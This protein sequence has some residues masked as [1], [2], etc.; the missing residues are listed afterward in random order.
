MQ[1]ACERKTQAIWLHVRDDNP[2]AIDL[3][4]QLGFTERARRT[5]WQAHTDSNAQMNFPNV[6]IAGRNPR[7]W[8]LQLNWLK[9][10]YPDPLAWHRQWNFNHLRPGFF[11]WLYLL[12]VDIEVRQ[13][14]AMK[15]DSPEAFLAWIPSG[16]GESLFAAA[17]ERSDPEALTALLLKA[18]RDL[19]RFYPRVQM[20]FPA[21]QFEQAIQNAGFQ[22][23]RTLIWMQATS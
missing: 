12:F 6:T 1:Y 10:L 21:G 2:G 14:A 9:R 22:S 3:Y 23:L 11:K 8:P 5:T 17:G 18:R 7:D 19:S 13:W 20:E 4:T 15:G 16:R